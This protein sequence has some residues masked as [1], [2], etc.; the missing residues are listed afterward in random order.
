MPQLPSVV[1][2]NGII[3]YVWHITESQELLLQMYEECHPPQRKSA[4]EAKE[5]TDSDAL[6]VSPHHK[7][8]LASRLLLKSV[9]G[10]HRMGRS[11]D[12]KPH[13]EY[14]E[15][16][17]IHTNNTHINYS[18]ADNWVVLACHP[19]LK[20]G[21]DIESPREQLH[22]I[23][24]RFCSEKETQW[25][26]ENPS[27]LQL[28]KAWCAKEALYKAIGKK[29]TDFRDQLYLHSMHEMESEMNATILLNT[30]KSELS[31]NSLIGLNPSRNPIQTTVYFFPLE[32]M[33]VAAVTLEN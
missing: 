23:Y 32:S 25:M 28:Q 10:N 2:P 5:I 3:V 13:L 20:V 31:K 18:H 19:E 17:D 22:R 4:S 1:L 26:G 15:H 16:A 12:G 14:I 6:T 30:E 24:R 27:T 7:H 8:F 29:G 21:I 9:F 33:M 11:E